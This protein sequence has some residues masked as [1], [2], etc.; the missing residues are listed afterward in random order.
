[1]K[2]LVLAMVIVMLLPPVMAANVRGE[3]SPVTCVVIN[4][5]PLPKVPSNYTVTVNP[6]S[7]KVIPGENA[8][9]DVYVMSVNKVPADISLDITGLPDSITAVFD[10]A[11]GRTDF[12]SKL[13]LYV[14]E[15]ICPGVY[16]PSIVAK[17]TNLQLAEFKL[18]IAGVGAVRETLEERM[19]ELQGRLD[20]LHDKLDELEDKI[21]HEEG[22]DRY[23]VSAGYFA[24][25]IISI[26]G[27][28][29]LGGFALFV[30]MR[31]VKKSKDNS[32]VIATS[33]PSS[34]AKLQDVIE[35]LKQLI[36][37]SRERFREEKVR[38]EVKSEGREEKTGTAKE[39][40]EPKVGDVWYAYCPVCGLRTEHGKDYDGS[41]CARC[42]NR[43]S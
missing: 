27:S 21:N 24:V 11:S 42:G 9:F 8:V 37:I 33:P 17:D 6:Q 40:T 29:L 4:N 22:N 20:A 23:D 3:G 15:M 1:L 2:R 30:L 38:H 41:F 13:T 18:E 12:A 32:H 31:H 14:N 25:L 39:T 5:P 7:A 43:S 28:F 35:L 19:D 36:D 34:D 26:I 10:P 16:A